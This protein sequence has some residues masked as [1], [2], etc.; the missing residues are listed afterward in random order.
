MLCRKCGSKMEKGTLF[1]SE[2]GTKVDDGEKTYTDIPVIIGGYDVETN[3]PIIMNKKKKSKVGLIIGIVL[4][5]IAL[6]II[7]IVSSLLFFSITKVNKK[8]STQ[9]FTIQ[10]KKTINV[11]KLSIEY[12][13]SEWEFLSSESSDNFKKFKNKKSNMAITYEKS[14][15]FI[16]TY[17]F[18]ENMRQEYEEDG[19][20]INGDT[21][22]I[23][24][25]KN[26]WKKI[27]YSKDD[28]KYLQLFYSTGYETYSYLFASSK[29][30]YKKEKS[31][32]KIAY[33]TL[34]YDI[35][36][37]I[38]GEEDAKK[39]L[40]GEWNWG[41]K[42]YFVFT[43]D[44][45][46]LYKDSSKSK[47][48]VLYGTYTADNKIATN[49]NGYVKGIHIIFTVDKCYVDGKDT[50]L[51]DNKAE[52]TF[53]KNSNGTYIIRNLSAGTYGTAKKIK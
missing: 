2:C 3:K 4:G 42:G 24:I 1:C 47:K 14:D 30:T 18:A 21:K 41:K 33:K 19:Y 15:S 36:E 51:V 48:N 44:K 32:A 9:P 38:D 13:A 50:K 53:T 11:N 5:I 12:D 39:I 22:D 26:T 27:E 45:V 8:T 46:Y 37:E 43:K 25:N 31:K 16:S 29:K 40:I 23:K 20:E 35:S 28:K 34:K 49:A 17:T 10:N 7:G 6:I 52:Y